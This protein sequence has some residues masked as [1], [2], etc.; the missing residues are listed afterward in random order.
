MKRLNIT[1]VSLKRMPALAKALKLKPYAAGQIVSWL[2]KK[3]VSSFDDM[4]NLS[5]TARDALKGNYDLKGLETHRLL[6]AKDG[7][8]KFVFLLEDGFK[9]ESVLIPSEKGRLTLCISTQVGC[10]MGC[11]FCRTG[12]M[13]LKRD[14]TQGE[15]LGQLIEVKRYLKPHKRKLTNIVFMGMGEPFVNYQAVS[16]AMGFILDERAFNFSR[17]RVTISTAGLLPQIKMFSKHFDVKLAISLNA[18][19]DKTRSKLMPINKRYPMAQVMRFCRDYCANSKHRITFEYVMIR[20]INDTKDDMKRLV[21][22]LNKVK[23]KVNLIPF[24]PFPGCAFKNPSESTVET[25]FKF[26]NSRDI[27]TNIRVSR[28]GDILAACGQ[29]A[30]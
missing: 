30:G 18:T 9:I 8:T 11:L 26:L 4:T 17:R 2:Y 5:K 25:W 1:D 3:R 27:Q 15:I 28:G 19:D 20:G 21:K 24:N 14:L 12:R 16:D 10:A 29:L 23:A 13:G 6:M 7:T 22:L